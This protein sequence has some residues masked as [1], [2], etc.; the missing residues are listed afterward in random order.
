MP[1]LRD[2]N[3]QDCE[4]L[5]RALHRLQRELGELGVKMKATA[6][7]TALAHW[8]TNYL[9][10]P[11]ETSEPH[12]NFV[13]PAYVSSRVENARREL[14]PGKMFDINSSFSHSMV[15]AIPGR[16][17]REDRIWK[18]DSDETDLT[19]ARATVTIR[20]CRFPPIPYRTSNQRI[21]FPTGTMSGMWTGV[22]LNFLLQQGH[23]IKKIERV[24]HYEPRFDMADYALD[25][26][27][28]KATEKDPFRKELWK[29]FLNALYGKMAESTQKDSLLLNPSSYPKCD[30]CLEPCDCVR[31]AWPGAYIVKTHHEVPHAHVPIAAYITA[32][33]RKRVSIELERT[34]AA[35][36]DTDSIATDIDNALPVSDNLGDWKVESCFSEALFLAPKLYALRLAEDDWKIRAKG[37][38]RITI[39]E[40][41]ALAS[42]QGVERN[43]MI[44]LKESIRT[45]GKIRPQ[46][47]KV[48][49]V[50]H[51]QSRPKR[52]FDSKGNS[53][54]WTVK[55]VDT[56][57]KKE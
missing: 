18:E 45:E 6:A 10:G 41:L 48:I 22:D 9:T 27:E 35:Y 8:R 43:R 28:K 44:R 54:P 24:W 26:Y 53:V 40:F 25:I 51:F 4:I 20:S 57:Y 37:F 5:Y 38:S 19:I 14:G 15:A 36:C 30:T 21:Y 52:R 49:K 17:V 55:D 12:N 39:K 23:K 29:L 32:R 50:A 47:L 33:S 1:I 7:S 34:N 11:I 56:P 13:R 42:G 3:K 31:E 16:L 46:D 2:Y